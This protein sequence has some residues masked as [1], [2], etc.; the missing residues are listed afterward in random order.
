M[1]GAAYYNAKDWPNAIAVFTD[2]SSFSRNHRVETKSFFR[3]VR[4]LFGVGTRKSHASFHLRCSR[5]P[6]TT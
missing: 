5:T 6:T 3:R 1:L 4:Q 2:T